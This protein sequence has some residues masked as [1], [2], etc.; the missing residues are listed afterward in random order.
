VV[1]R[2]ALAKS[3]L[4]AKSV[5]R[6]TYSQGQAAAGSSMSKAAASAQA[7]EPVASG[8]GTGAGAG[9]G[10]HGQQSVHSHGPLPACSF[11]K[12]RFLYIARGK[13]CVG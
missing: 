1:A 11:R 13:S 9:T 6:P 8:V 4:Q 5:L 3:V 12:L 2:A 10:R 7:L